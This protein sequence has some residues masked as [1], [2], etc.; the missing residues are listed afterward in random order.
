MIRQ[1]GPFIIDK[2]YL[3]T[4]LPFRL[5]RKALVAYRHHNLEPDDIL[6]ASYPKSGNTWMRALLS[7]LIGPGAESFDELTQYVPELERVRKTRQ[8]FRLPSGGR[9]VKTHEP[10][11]R[12]YRRGVYIVRDCREVVVSRYF[13]QLRTGQFNGKFEEFLQR[14]LAGRVDGYG[15]WD[16]H[17][18]SW[19]EAKRCYPDSFLI[20]KYEDMIAD[21]EST[22]ARVIT[23]LGLQVTSEDVGNAIYSNSRERMRQKENRTASLQAKK[24]RE[25]P[26]VRISASEYDLV[27]EPRHLEQLNE[28]FEKTLQQLGYL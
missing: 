12:C 28:T 22:L 16:D 17:V 21:L 10:W 27:I 18:A 9:L 25:I 1:R 7:S 5:I 23:F 11:H 4:S 19:L 6:I 26:F 24:K 8:A 20:I 14:F 15:R 13:D 3:K 2:N